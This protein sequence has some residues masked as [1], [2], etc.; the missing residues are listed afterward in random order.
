[1]TTLNYLTSF[2]EIIENVQQPKVIYQ[3]EPFK[4]K[5]KHVIIGGDVIISLIA[6]GYYFGR[7]RGIK[8]TTENLI[9]K[10]QIKKLDTSEE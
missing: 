9:R 4:L 2:S 6:V 5:T 3:S 8:I 10:Y 1:M 7:E